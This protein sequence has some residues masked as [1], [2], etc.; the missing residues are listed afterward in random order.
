MDNKTDKITKKL[1]SNVKKYAIEN[2]CKLTS[3]TDYRIMNMFLTD[4]LTD[5][6]Q[7]VVAANLYNWLLHDVYR[8]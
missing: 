8:Y 1:I 4:K 6:E 2:D 3:F 7:C 5:D